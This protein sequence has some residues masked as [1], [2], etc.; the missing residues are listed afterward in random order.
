MP[1]RECLICSMEE[2]DPA[3]RVFLDELWAAE[4][5]PGYEVPA[6]FFLRSRRH[7]EKLT[8]LDDAETAKK[9][10]WNAD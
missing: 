10:P 8:G 2:A 4:V 6:W 9:D 7:A 1:D 5:A 3:S